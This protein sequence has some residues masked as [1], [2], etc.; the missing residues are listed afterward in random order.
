MTIT[1]YLP[2]W[3]RTR[4]EKPGPSHAP[5]GIK[6]RTQVLPVLPEPPAP[7]IQAHEKPSA[8]RLLWKI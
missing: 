8:M 4:L 2:R 6:K 3:L 5:I 7:P 1:R